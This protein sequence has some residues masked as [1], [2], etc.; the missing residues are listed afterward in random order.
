MEICAIESGS[1]SAG[2]SNRK[3][4]RALHPASDS[5]LEGSGQ[6]AV[7][8]AQAGGGF[9]Q[10]HPVEIEGNRFE[11]CIGSALLVVPPI[12]GNETS[13][14][15]MEEVPAVHLIFAVRS[16]IELGRAEE[17][18][19]CERAQP[20]LLMN[21]AKNG[22]AGGFTMTN[23]SGRNLNTSIREVGVRENEQPC[24]VGDVRERLLDDY[25]GVGPLALPTYRR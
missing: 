2:C 25:H 12:L 23:C 18:H 11:C 20:G 14:R 17:G 1:V 15:K 6:C 5:I 7:I 16:R 3:G 9:Q 4:W 8:K 22:G 19:G 24:F 10:R 13:V 21:L